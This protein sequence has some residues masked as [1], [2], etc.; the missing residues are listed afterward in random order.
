MVQRPTGL[1]KEEKRGSLGDDA[2]LL[3]T[4]RQVAALYGTTVA[5]IQN[6]E[7]I[8]KLKPLR[9]SRSST[10]QVFFTRANVLAVIEE[11]SHG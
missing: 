6:L 9:L 2:Q 1:S 10:A 11:A 8:G 3:Y 4:R 7:K 5:Y